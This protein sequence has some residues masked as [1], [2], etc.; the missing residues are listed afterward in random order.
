VSLVLAT[1]AEKEMG[2]G[3]GGRDRSGRGRG[4]RYNHFATS[5]T[6]FFFIVGAELKILHTLYIYIFFTKRNFLSYNIFNTLFIIKIGSYLFYLSI[7]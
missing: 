3:G 7:Q 2:R 6:I 1:E 4:D 5:L